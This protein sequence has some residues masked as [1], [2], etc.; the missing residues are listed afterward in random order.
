MKI[1][2]ITPCYN[3][4]RFLQKAL[5]SVHEQVC[6]QPSNLQVEH[7]VID[8]GSADGTVDLLQAFQAKVGGA[9]GKDNAPTYS[10][11]WI[12]EPDK[13]QSDAINKGLRMATGDVVC[14]LN[15]DEHY[16]ASVLGKIADAF[17]KNPEVD[18]IYGEPVFTDKNGQIVKKKVEHRFDRR[19]LL[20]YGC[21]IT[22]CC[23]FWRRQIL[24]DGHYLDESYKATMD[25]EYYVRLMDLGYTFLFLPETIASF[26]WHEE[27]ISTV[28]FDVRRTERLQVQRRYGVQL[29]F[30]SQ[31]PVWVLDGLAKVFKVKRFIMTIPRRLK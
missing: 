18:V 1:S 31:T 22:S 15:A 23:T 21:Y 7:I 14:W 13:G 24:E 26:M 28:F 3:Y 25:F 20:Y 6:N 12:S 27:N 10:L 9:I 16:Y 29:P 30:F 2:V 4:A 8:G 17:E 19:I 5:E 11:Q